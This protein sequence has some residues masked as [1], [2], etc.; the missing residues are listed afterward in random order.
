MFSAEY[1]FFTYL[2][3]E[4]FCKTQGFSTTTSLTSACLFSPYKCGHYYIFSLFSIGG[5]F[6]MR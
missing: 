4:L 1:S 2:Y 3:F 5:M 6:Q